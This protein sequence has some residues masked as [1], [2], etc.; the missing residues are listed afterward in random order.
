MKGKMRQDKQ[1]RQTLNLIYTAGVYV[2][3][4]V[5]TVTTVDA[6]STKE[7]VFITQAQWTHLDLCMEL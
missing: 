5:S 6:L 2:Y 1:T 4:V 7:G 3:I